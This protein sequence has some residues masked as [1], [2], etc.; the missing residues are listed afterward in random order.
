M[1]YNKCSLYIIYIYFIVA[2]LNSNAGNS[3]GNRIGVTADLK[4]IIP[5]VIIGVLLCCLCLVFGF[6]SYFKVY[7]RILQLEFRIE[8]LRQQNREGGGISSSKNSDDLK[9]LIRRD[10]DDDDDNDD[11]NN[12]VDEEKGR[13][14]EEEEK[15]KVENKKGKKKE[16]E[17]EMEES[18]LSSVDKNKKENLPKDQDGSIVD[19]ENGIQMRL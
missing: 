18:K 14:E 7:E 5:V 9:R 16:I 17:E 3:E 8:K 4:I 12:D 6:K 15:K 10:S 19:D 13:A 11:D 2:D 1:L